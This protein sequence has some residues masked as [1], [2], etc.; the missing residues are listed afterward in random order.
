M[1]NVCVWIYVAIAR[2]MKLECMYS[3][4]VVGG[5]PSPVQYNILMLLVGILH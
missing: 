4:D 3:M 2:R 1:G 5:I